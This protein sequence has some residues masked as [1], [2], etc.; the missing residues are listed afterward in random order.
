LKTE[1]SEKGRYV[2]Y[3]HPK[4]DYMVECN[5]F[6]FIEN[7]LAA[8]VLVGP[9]DVPLGMVSFSKKTPLFAYM[10]LKE[11]VELLRDRTGVS[12]PL[13]TPAELTD[14]DRR[15]KHILLCGGIEPNPV[16]EELD[17]AGHLRDPLCETDNWMIVPNPWNVGTNVLIVKGA[18][19]TE[20][21]DNIRALRCA[22]FS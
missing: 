1:H 17:H 14:E 4:T 18:A 10:H 9:E 11:I 16:V 8:C 12:L 7:G 6:K 20:M 15:T 2:V 19:E 3:V 5:G 21:V 22:L 13:K